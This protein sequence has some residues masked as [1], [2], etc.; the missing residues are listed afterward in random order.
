METKVTY[1][2]VG[3]FILTLM[4]G[5]LGGLVWLSNWDFS[6]GR[7]Y[8]IYFKGSISGLRENETV[9]YNGIPIGFVK[10]IDID[11]ERMDAIR[12][13]AK[14]EKPE[15]V[16]KNARASLEVKGLS[17]SLFIR[18]YGS[19][20]QDPP[21]QRQAG[22]R[23]PVIQAERSAFQTLLDDAPKIVQ[24]LSSLTEKIAPFFDDKNR[25][26]FQQILKGIGDVAAGF[27]QYTSNSLSEFGQLMREVHDMSANF[28][29]M[30]N[31]FEDSPR[32]F[33]LQEQQ[34]DG[35]VIRP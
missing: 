22:E 19:D 14:I 6:D 10:R 4:L 3:L 29:R 20:P 7:T 1:V 23:Y 28:N 31:K 5:T 16:R 21:L 18:I 8:A 32:Q 17:G 13:L 25:E 9:T 2:G 27:D 15:L 30:L 24:S 11:P 35:Y 34:K 33:L 26:Q 12:I